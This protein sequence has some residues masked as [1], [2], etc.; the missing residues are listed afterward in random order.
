MIDLIEELKKIFS[1]TNDNVIIEQYEVSDASFDLMDK[2]EKSICKENE[3]NVTYKNE[4]EKSIYVLNYEKL[5]QSLPAEKRKGIKHCDFIL[6]E[7]DS[8]LICNELSMGTDVKSKWPK[9]WKQ[10][11]Q[12]IQIL[13]KS[14]FIKEKLS[15]INYKCCVFSTRKEK[16]KSPSGIADA[17]NI[18][19]E[20][21]KVVQEREWYPINQLGFKVF[22]S[23][24]I[25]YK[26]DRSLQFLRSV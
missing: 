16:I 25:I 20:L 11:Q 7:T 2:L 18:S 13:N 5:I 8:F 3:G 23:D 12:T 4:S 17:F 22:E 24:Y 6:S 14:D 15:N 9:A 19:Y 26:K 10:M 21:I 1:A